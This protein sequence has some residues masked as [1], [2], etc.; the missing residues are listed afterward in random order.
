VA[1][2]AFAAAAEP[3]SAAG[4]PQALQHGHSALQGHSQS[5]PHRTVGA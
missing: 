4:A 5:V 3:S 2:A 1:A